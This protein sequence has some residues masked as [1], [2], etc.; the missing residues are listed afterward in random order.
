MMIK[1][2]GGLEEFPVLSMDNKWLICINLPCIQQQITF[3]RWTYI[4]YTILMNCCLELLT[5]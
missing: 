2:I 3:I 4:E 5:V 1:S